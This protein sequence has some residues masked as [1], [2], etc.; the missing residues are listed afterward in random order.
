MSRALVR[1]YPRW[2]RERYGD[3]FEV[4]L[5]DLSNDG[6]RRLWIMADVARDAART[7]V[8]TFFADPAI[9]RGIYDGLI[10]TAFLAVEIVLTNVV[11]PQG[12]NESDSDPEYVIPYLIELAILASLLVVVGFRGRRRL[13]T[14]FAGVK[15]GAAAGLVLAFTVTLI[16]LAMNNAFFDIISQQ[17]DK[18]VAFAASGWTSMRA[19]VSVQQLLGLT[20]LVPMM[21]IV[22][23]GLGWLGGLLG[24]RRRAA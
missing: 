7:R 16:F 4:L 22:G 3:E 9:R 10:I 8:G 20:I 23:S 24:R 18:R 14:T 15:A 11:F 19:Y 12:P 2:W 13:N 17:H 1:L 6:Y 5:H 21:F